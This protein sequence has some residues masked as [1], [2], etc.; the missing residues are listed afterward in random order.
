M[1]LL[2]FSQYLSACMSKTDYAVSTEAT[3]KNKTKKQPVM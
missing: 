3:N 2:F 1:P